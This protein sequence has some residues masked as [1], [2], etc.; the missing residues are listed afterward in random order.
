MEISPILNERDMRMTLG[1]GRDRGVM[2]PLLYELVFTQIEQK[3]DVQCL[4]NLCLPHSMRRWLDRS[5][6]VVSGF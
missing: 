5:G 2:I 4:L 1:D 6:G 3:L